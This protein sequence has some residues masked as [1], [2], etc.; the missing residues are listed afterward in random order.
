MQ[1]IIILVIYGGIK[2]VKHIIL[3]NLKDEYTDI[4]KYEI[5]K[6]IKVKLEELLGQIPGL[7][8]IKVQIQ[9]LESSSADLMLDSTFE[10]IEALRGYAIHPKHVEVA[11]N[12]VRPYTALRSCIDY[13]I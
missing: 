11:D 6:N 13:E 12:F 4:E 2:M 1:L 9:Y 3:W 7:V 10:S 5:K 8:D